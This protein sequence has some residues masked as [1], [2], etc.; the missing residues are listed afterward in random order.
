[1]VHQDSGGTLL[2]ETGSY[3]KCS[4]F[5]SAFTS[6]VHAWFCSWITASEDGEMITEGIVLQFL[7]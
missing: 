7:L 3:V 2:E 4:V 5:C 1:M 6:C